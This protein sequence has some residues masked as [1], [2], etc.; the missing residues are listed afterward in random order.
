MFGMTTKRLHFMI[1]GA[2]A[3]I[4][5]RTAVAPL[6]RMH[7]ILV[8]RSDEDG[9]KMLTDLLKNEGILGLWRGNTVNCMK[10]APTTA[11]KFFV[12]ENLKRF[13]KEYYTKKNQ[14]LPFIVNFG[15][16]ALGAITSTMVSHPIDVIRTRMSI[17]TTKIRKYDGFFGTAKTIIKEEGITGLYKGL[18]FS[19]LSVTPFQAVNHACFDIVSPLVPECKLKKLYQGCLSSS[20]AFSLCYPLDVVKR[21]LLAKK[22]DSAT[23]AI[24]TIIKTQGIKGFYSGFSVGFVKVVP[25]MSVQF[26]AFDQYK[27]FFKL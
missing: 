3:G 19:I 24:K 11:V 4:V 21:K 14:K 8:A 13:A 7:T 20:L 18:G 6:D 27:K 26:F 1:G 12:T 10:V 23:D 16:G 25:M 22:A 17:E 5:S 9:K 2:F 15:I